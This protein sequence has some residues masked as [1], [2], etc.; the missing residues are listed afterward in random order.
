VKKY[1]VRIEHG[2]QIEFVNVRARS[3]DEAMNE[4]LRVLKLDYS[5]VGKIIA[6]EA[7]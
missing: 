2:T 4:A 6:E 7:K 3:G 5:R 1:R